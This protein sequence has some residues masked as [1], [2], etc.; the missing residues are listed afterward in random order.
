M[1]WMDTSEDCDMNVE[2]SRI[3]RKDPDEFL[4][5]MRIRPRGFRAERMVPANVEMIFHLI[6]GRALFYYR[7][8]TLTMQKGN[9]IKL[10][11]RTLYSIRC[12]GSNRPAYLVVRV[13]NMVAAASQ[14][15]EV[16]AIEAVP[17]PATQPL[18]DQNARP[19]PGGQ[20]PED[21]VR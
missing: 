5:I 9:Y 14:P 16:L 6:T 4:A 2:V 13:N 3:L 11:P 7:R 18:A 12:L 17:P 15:S 1:V 10:P 8:Q 21:T 19:S 20:I